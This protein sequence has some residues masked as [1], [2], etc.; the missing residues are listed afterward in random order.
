MKGILTIVFLLGSSCALVAQTATFQCAPFP[1]VSNF[2]TWRDSTDLSKNVPYRVGSTREGALRSAY[3]NIEIGMS[4][5]EVE[6]V[7]GKPEF[8]NVMAGGPN[9]GPRTYCIDQW[10]YI[11]RKNSA[12]IID[13]GD[14]AIYLTFSA[15]EKLYWASPQNIDLKSKG[16]AVH[17]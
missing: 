16:S 6:K 12:I 1:G 9:G 11:F 4:R 8:E 10:V 15:D 5:S 13:A 17:K 7:M 3:A 14:Q 2:R